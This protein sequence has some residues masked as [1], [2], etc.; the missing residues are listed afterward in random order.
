MK[1][2]F[3]FF[4]MLLLGGLIFASLALTSC[5]SDDDDDVDDGKIDPTTIATANLVAYFPFDGDPTEEIESLSP[6]M[7]PG[8]TYVEGRRGQAYQGANEAHLLYT[9]PTTSKLKTLTSFSLAMWFKSPLVTGD[10]EPTVFE[11]GKSTDF[12][13]GNLKFA[14][15]RLDATADSLKI[16]AFFF[17]EGAVWSGQ[18][19]SYSNNVFVTGM[20]MH[21][22]IQ[23]DATTSKFMIYK[24]GVKIETSE[25]V[26]NRWAAGDDVTPRPPLGALSFVNADVI[27]IGAWR[28]KSEGTAEDAWM[29]WFLGNLDELRVYDKALSGVEVKSLYDAEITQ[30]N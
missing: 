23:Y 22:V 3:K 27:N 7:M 20:W 8:V 18:H 12:F 21:L 26:E 14:L 29:G 17:K 2:K 24:D 25:G 16:K 13:W 1:N 15:N 19:I 10:P 5:S 11:I 28:P 9:L 6:T 4:G 30:I